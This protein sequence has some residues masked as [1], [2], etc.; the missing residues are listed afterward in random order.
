MDGPNSRI[1]NNYTQNG[2]GNHQLATWVSSTYS[3]GISCCII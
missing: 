2:G 3:L 1:L